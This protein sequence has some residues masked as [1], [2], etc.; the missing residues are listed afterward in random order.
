MSFI[1]RRTALKNAACGFGYLALA[2]LTARQASADSIIVPSIANPL[3]NK[4]PHFSPRAKRIIFLFMQGGV[5]HVDSFDHKPELL[6]QD[7]KSVPFDDARAIANSGTRGTP[8][9]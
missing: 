4:P 3:A 2:G 5:S 1:T 8:Q 9:K 6:K 7:G